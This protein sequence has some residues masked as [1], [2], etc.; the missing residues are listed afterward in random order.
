MNQTMMDTGWQQLQCRI[1]KYVRHFLKEDYPAIEYK[2]RI[3][4][5]LPLPL[6]YNEQDVE[7]AS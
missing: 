5:F 4:G 7:K 6:E 1:D 3:A 2:T